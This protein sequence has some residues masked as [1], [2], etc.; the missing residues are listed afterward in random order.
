MQEPW[1]KLIFFEI[2]EFIISPC[3]N[4]KAAFDWFLFVLQPTYFFAAS[5]NTF[6]EL[7]STDLD[8]GEWAVSW[9]RE[10]PVVINK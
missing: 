6:Y 2:D 1:F 10:K 8:A 7:N 3:L 5:A 9:G 4:T